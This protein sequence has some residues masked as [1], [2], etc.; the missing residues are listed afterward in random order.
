MISEFR[1]I[2]CCNILYKSIAK[3][4]T[5]R[6]KLCLPS[7]I[8]WNQSAFVKRRRI[9]DNILLGH[10]VVRDYHKS[11]GKPRC[12]VKI[13]LKKAFDSINWDFVLHT[14]SAMGFPPLYLSW[15]KECIS[16]PSYS[17]KIN[18]SLEGCFAGMKGIRQGDSLSPYIFVICMEVLSNMLDKAFSSREISYHPLC[19]KIGLT[20]FCFAD[21]LIIVAEASVQSL[22]NIQ[23]LSSISSILSEFYS[24]SG[25]QVNLHKSEVFFCKISPTN[26]DSYWHAGYEKSRTPCHILRGST[27][28]W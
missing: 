23:S 11:S 26:Q 18:G 19:K 7:L 8:S 15:I 22:S 5:N 20:H 16:S 3:I 10:E 17:I 21:D 14:M 27:H 4:L 13:D 24:L 1:P 9:I 28:F 6:L 12:T 2:S 25:L